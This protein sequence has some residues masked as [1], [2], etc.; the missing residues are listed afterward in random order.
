MLTGKQKRYLRSLAVNEKAIFQIGKDEPTENTYRSIMEALKARELVKVSVLKTC[1]VDLNELVID[2]C[3]NTKADL[4]QVIGRTI[5]LY[6][7]SK[8]RKI[9]L[10]C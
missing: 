10:P 2:M 9:N 7:P 1:M 6:K 5:V 8:D 4:V 3:A